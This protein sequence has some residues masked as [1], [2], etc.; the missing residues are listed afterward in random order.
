MVDTIH[1][2]V[3]VVDTGPGAAAAANLIRNIRSEKE[4][5]VKAVKSGESKKAAPV[6]NT[7]PSADVSGVVADINQIVYQVSTTKISF[8]IDEET[9]LSIIRVVNRETGDIIRQLPT[10]ELLNLVSKMEQ[11]RGLIFDREI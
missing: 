4:V 1:N 11:L 5:S 10:E 9:G 6:T 7:Q 2:I 8:D 3:S